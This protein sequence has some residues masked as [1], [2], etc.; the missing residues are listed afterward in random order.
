MNNLSRSV[1]RG[2]A[3]G[4]PEWKGEFEIAAAR[5]SNLSASFARYIGTE[6]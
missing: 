5:G 3:Q 6:K 4:G 2:S 1:A